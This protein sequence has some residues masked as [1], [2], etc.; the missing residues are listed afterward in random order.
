MT[1]VLVL[2][3]YGLAGRA[4][5]DRLLRATSLRVIA[6]GRRQERLETEFAGRASARLHLRRLDAESAEALAAACADADVV[7]N[8]V[9]PYNLSGA[10]IARTAVGCRRHYVDCANEQIHYE[11]LRAVD[12]E[13]RE[14]GLLVATAAGLIPGLSTLLAARFLERSPAATRVD[15]RYA[16]LRHAFADGGHASVMG[17]VL[18]AVYRP[19]AIR[20]GRRVE[21][22]LGSSTD[23]VELRPPFGSRTFLE[24]PNIDVPVLA[25]VRKLEEAHT[26]IHLG[27][28]PTWLFRLIRWLDPARRPWAYRLISA[29]VEKL[30]RHEYDEAV[31][32]GAGADAYVQV[33]VSGA[34]TPAMAGVHFTDGATPTAILPV[35]LVTDLDAG[36]LTRRG[37]VT[38][39]DVYSWEDVVGELADCV[40]EMDGDMEKSDSGSTN[41]EAP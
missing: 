14:N 39:V 2:G 10:A 6:T 22:A 28:Q 24:V 25:Q 15:I 30:T 20:G 13:A 19:S 8:A 40:V 17:G 9:G 34:G 5:V 23:R 7:I 41:A 26:W 29:V 1:T 37:L 3:A 38:P 12:E 21:V 32:R 11:R 31:A 36:R 16:Q 18:D 33:E 35:R 27:D 4:I